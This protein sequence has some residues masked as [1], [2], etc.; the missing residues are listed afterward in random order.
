MA[1]IEIVGDATSVEL[2]GEARRYPPGPVLPGHYNVLAAFPNVE[3]RIKAGEVDL[4]PGERKRL[5][6]SAAFQ[7]CQ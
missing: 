2:R 4:K 5:S 6:C 7:K 3:G 1:F